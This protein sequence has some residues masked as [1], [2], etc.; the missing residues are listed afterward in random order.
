MEEQYPNCKILGYEVRI[1]CDYCKAKESEALILQICTGCKNHMYCG[2]EC[3]LKAWPKHKEMCRNFSSG[4]IGKFKKQVVLHQRMVE[5]I[6]EKNIPV[7]LDQMNHL[8]DDLG[9]L[10]KE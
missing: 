4:R 2:K 9:C 7:T 6:G 1:D 8:F 3:Q 5:T 10:I